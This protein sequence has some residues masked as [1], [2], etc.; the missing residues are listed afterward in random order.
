MNTTGVPCG[1]QELE[2]HDLIAPNGLEWANLNIVNVGGQ[3][4]SSFATKDTAIK[5]MHGEGIN[6]IYKNIAKYSTDGSAL[7]DEKQAEIFK[8]IKDYCNSNTYI[9]LLAWCFSG[10]WATTI[11]L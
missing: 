2:K 6:F 3:K 11:G 4:I 7:T 10:A 1:M 5:G 8:I 9:V